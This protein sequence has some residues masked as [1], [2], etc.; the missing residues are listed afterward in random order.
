VVTRYR[1]ASTRPK[2][3]DIFENTGSGSAN[4]PGSRHKWKIPHGLVD[5]S[6]A[7]AS[8]A[9]YES[10]LIAKLVRGRP[11]EQCRRYETT[12]ASTGASSFDCTVSSHIV[13]I[14]IGNSGWKLL[15]AQFPKKAED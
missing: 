6:Q 9:E 3:L 7:L 14:D 8:V 4:P 12:T 10:R 5:S 15:F 11:V 1:S 2:R 13:N